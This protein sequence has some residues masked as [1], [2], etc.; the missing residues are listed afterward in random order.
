MLGGVGNRLQHDPVSGHHQRHRECGEVAVASTETSILLQPWPSV[1][2]LVRKA[3]TWPRPR[4][5]GGA[6]RPRRPMP[7]TA[8]W[9][10]AAR[11]TGGC[12]P[13]AGT[14]RSRRATW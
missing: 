14:E 6:D 11:G 9:V 5:A 7:A 2:A 3:A 12:D 8:P 10:S 13:L 4:G 1:A